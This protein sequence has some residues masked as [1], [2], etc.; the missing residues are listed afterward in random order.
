MK[1]KDEA[2]ARKLLSAALAPVLGAGEAALPFG[3][4][5][6]RLNS[7]LHLLNCSGA[8]RRIRG[9]TEEGRHLREVILSIFDAHLDADPTWTGSN[10][11]LNTR[12]A[13]K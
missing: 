2:H 9:D 10:S 6:V 1:I 4:S 7:N 3:L 13:R 5:R 11:T 8:D 12:P